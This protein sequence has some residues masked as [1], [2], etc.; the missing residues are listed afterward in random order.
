MDRTERQRKIVEIIK[1]NDV[2]TQEDLAN[3]LNSMG[4]KVTQATVSRDIKELKLVKVNQNGR[5]K[6][7][8]PQPSQEVGLNRN[9]LTLYREVVQSVTVSLNL[10]VVRTKVGNANSVCAM[11]DT[12]PIPGVLGTIAGD[13]AILIVADSAESA[14]AIAKQLRSM[15]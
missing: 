6:Y 9:M 3:R 8:L 7:A 14:P 4:Y 12:V 10:V 1:A 2:D 11:L 15:F 13:D 5:Y